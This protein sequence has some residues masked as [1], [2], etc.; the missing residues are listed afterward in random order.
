MLMDENY[1]QSKKARYVASIVYLAV[2]A[3]L[4]TGT[5]IS[6]QHK[7]AAPEPAQEQLS[8]VK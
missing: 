3:F 1:K 5:L 7:R 2:L 8:V 4:V 6:E